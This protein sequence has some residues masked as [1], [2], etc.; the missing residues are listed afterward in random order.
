MTV[1]MTSNGAL[2]ELPKCLYDY[3][4]GITG[5]LNELPKCL[6]VY[7]HEKHWCIER[8]TQMFV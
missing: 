5:A 1:T 8:T 7:D 3:D 6:Y 4:H 2:K